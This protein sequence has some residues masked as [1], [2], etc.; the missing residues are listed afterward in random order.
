M[1]DDA[2]QT[3]TF[4]DHLD[5]LRKVI[6]RTVAVVAV[7]ATLAFI[8]KDFIFDIVF[9]PHQSN[10]ITYRLLCELGTYLNMPSL[11]P[12]EF[13][14]EL[15]NTELAAQFLTHMSISLYAGIL[16][17][18]PYIV[19]LL[20]R[21]I[22]PA[23]YEN[24]RKYSTRVIVAAFTLFMLGVLLNYYIIFPLSFRFL[25]T[26]QV[27]EF[28]VNRISLSSYISTFSILSIMMGIVFEIPVVAFFLGKVGLV[29]PEMLKRYRRH[30]FVVISIIAAFITPTAD[31][32]TLLLVATPMYVLYELSIFVVKKAGRK[33]NTSIKNTGSEE[34]FENPYHYD[35]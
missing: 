13:H 14:V 32:F 16:V 24:E 10:F 2:K 18:S 17:A 21:F 34:K 1:S 22:S 33:K 3:M 12:E 19:F 29:E 35:D 26:Y 28:V 11:C 23:L 30:A 25:G 15:I 31:I 6:F 8:C 20:F 9:A 27:S 5:E 7:F 4:W